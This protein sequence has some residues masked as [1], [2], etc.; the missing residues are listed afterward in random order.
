[1]CKHQ[2]YSRRK[3]NTAFS[4]TDEW[5]ACVYD[6]TTLD[7]DGQ[8]GEIDVQMEHGRPYLNRPW[9]SKAAHEQTTIWYQIISLI[10]KPSVS[11]Q[12]FSHKV[13]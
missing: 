10:A 9:K 1:M 2:W 6:Y 13:S 8:E 3:S 11:F 5:I 12:N 7:G 4:P